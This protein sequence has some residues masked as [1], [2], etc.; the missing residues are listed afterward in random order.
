MRFPFF[1]NRDSVK[2]G[3]LI[4]IRRTGDGF[5][6]GLFKKSKKKVKIAKRQI[7]KMLINGEQITVQ[8]IEKA[9]GLSNSF[10]YRNKEIKAVL[11]EA[12]RKQQK[13]CNSIEIIKAIEA[14]ETIIA[15]KTD[16][17]R[18]E[19][20]LRKAE[21]HEEKLIIENEKLRQVLKGYEKNGF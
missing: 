11:D 18:L 13:P 17:A 6:P 5:H 16:I 10:F 15:L 4:S 14:E 12:K 3:I 19:M 1:R 9:T 8:E 20:K 21:I 2:N 7:Q